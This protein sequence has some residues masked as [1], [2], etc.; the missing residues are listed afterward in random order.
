MKQF[1]GVIFITFVLA[2]LVVA[3]DQDPL[4]R[5]RKKVAGIYSLQR[6]EDSKTYYLAAKGDKKSGGGA[7][8]G[9]VMQIGWNEHCIVAKRHSMFRGDPDGWMI[10]NIH[11]QSI[12]GPFS[13]EVIRTRPETKG[14]DLLYP[15]EAWKKL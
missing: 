11:Q 2:L 9:I 7:L 8:D 12:E 14:M 13:D 3:C 6:W 5:S 10:V 4:G 1:Y 15:D